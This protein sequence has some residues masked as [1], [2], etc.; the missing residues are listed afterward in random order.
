[1]KPVFLALAAA[2]GCVSAVAAPNRLYLAEQYDWSGNRGFFL[3]FEND[4]A[5]GPCRLSTLQLILGVADGGN[6]RY[7]FHQPAWQY[8]RTYTARAVIKPSGCELWLDGALIGSKPGGYAPVGAELSAGTV[9]S[10]AAGAAEYLIVQSG[11]EATGS[12]GQS[13]TLDMSVEANRPVPLMLMAPR[14][15]RRSAWSPIVGQ[16]QTYTAT[17]RIIPYP[18]PRAYDPYVDRYGQARW[19]DFAGKV[20]ADADLLASDTEEANRLGAWGLPA[21]VDAYGGSTDAGWTETPSG[22]FRTVKRNGFWWL[23][24]PD[25]NPCFYLGVCDAPA[26]SWEMT[27]VTDR[28][29]VFA[30]LPPKTAPYSA[31]WG[32]D[33]WG[34]GQ[35]T[36][37]VA[38]H[39]ANMIR[40]Y[41]SG[42]M[43]RARSSTYTRVRTLGFSGLAK[44][45]DSTVGL[46][47][48]PV[49]YT[50]GV[51]RLVRHPD[52]FDPSIRTQ[53]RN[54]LAGQLAGFAWEP[55]VVGY[56]V[57]SE[58]D[59][60]VTPEETTAILAMG[61]TVPAKRALVDYALANLYGGSVSATAA[62]WKVPATTVAGLYASSPTVP[63][64]DVEA[65]RRHYADRYYAF[66]YETCK[67]LDSV[68]LYMGNWL[69][70]GWWVNEEDWRLV[71][72]HCDVMGID[73]YSFHFADA[74]V[75]RL[76]REMDKPVFVGEFSYPP[77]YR[78][79]RGFG[80]YEASWGDDEASSAVLYDRY[81][82][83]GAANPYCVGVCWFEY[84]DQAPTG[85]GPGRGTSLVYGENYA[86]GLVDMTDRLKWDLVT[87]MR[88][89]NL[90]AAGVRLGEN[91]AYRPYVLARRALE[92]CAG[93]RNATDDDIVQLDTV[94]PGIIDQAD[95][96]ALAARGL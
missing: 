75:A 54:V 56:T 63:P 41:G 67:E 13:L 88:R 43:N 85:R 78:G 74:R 93:L 29:S 72:R 28:T 22:F 77:S 64:A 34:E 16:T 86:F 90:A 50:A 80:T 27:P 14:A 65:L 31:C 2:I 42:W 45:S 52:V 19:A 81:V 3:D 6:W 59:E 39:T 57:G 12:G 79:T 94:T 23:I 25:G 9:P 1:M 82:R 66:L 47:Y 96:V 37:Y 51:A 62:A 49:V 40:K 89:T 68:H 44:W 21:N 4:A 7:I 20:T 8:N 58:W 33:V 48:I 55:L 76:I 61:A 87:P 70:P 30:E 5:S 24:T 53:L 83:D 36:S 91:A 10:W 60:I 35:G 26:L 95:A 73:N 71:A 15:N 69:V 18:D 32:T 92:V 11:L 38:F 84:R 17:F 46:P